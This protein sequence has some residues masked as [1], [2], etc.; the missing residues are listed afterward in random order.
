VCSQG[1]PLL[2]GVLLRVQRASPVSLLALLSPHVGEVARQFAQ[3]ETILGG[4][5]QSF[6][7]DVWLYMVLS[8]AKSVA[9]EARVRSEPYAVA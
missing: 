2:P 3:A 7:D 1:A 8:R 5:L 6:E 9:A 4:F